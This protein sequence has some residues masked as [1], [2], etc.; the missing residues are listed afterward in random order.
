[1][2]WA[3]TIPNCADSNADSNAVFPTGLVVPGDKGRS[4]RTHSVLLQF[5]GATNRYCLGPLEEWEKLRFAVD[6]GLFYN[7]IEQLVLEQFQ[8]EPPFRWG[9]L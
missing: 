3:T 6:G 1:M 8:G 2:P 7:P 5:M 4:E 9:A